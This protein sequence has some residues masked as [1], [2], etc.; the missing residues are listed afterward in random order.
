MYINNSQIAKQFQA[1]FHPENKQ[2]HRHMANALITII[3]LMLLS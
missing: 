3:M 1:V 2:L